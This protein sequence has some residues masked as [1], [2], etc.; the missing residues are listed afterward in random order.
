MPRAL[1]TGVGE[2]V[3]GEVGLGVRGGGWKGAG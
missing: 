1:R 2:A 3:R